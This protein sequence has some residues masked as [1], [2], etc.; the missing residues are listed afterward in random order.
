MFQ[1]AE[2]DYFIPPAFAHCVML[3]GSCRFLSM[4]KGFYFYS[5]FIQMQ[6][7]VTMEVKCV[8]AIILLTCLEVLLLT[9]HS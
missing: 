3:M 9:A 7:F 4:H 6:R 5:Y 1:Y 2:L 8:C